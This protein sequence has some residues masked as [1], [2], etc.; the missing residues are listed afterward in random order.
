M[1]T[2]M[3][4]L[5]IIYWIEFSQIRN[6]KNAP[7][8]TYSQLIQ[9]CQTDWPRLETDDVCQNMRW[10]NNKKKKFSIQFPQGP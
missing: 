3:T 1:E 5:E 7:Q 10:F 2:V 8:D 4:S 9:I 6:L